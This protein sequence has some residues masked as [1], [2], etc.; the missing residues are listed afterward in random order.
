M[1]PC[2]KK[3]YVICSSDLLKPLVSL[4]IVWLLTL[5]ETLEEIAKYIRGFVN[6]DPQPIAWRRT[7]FPEAHCPLGLYG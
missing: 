5:K 3:R 7:A 1:L 6:L 4:T 2:E